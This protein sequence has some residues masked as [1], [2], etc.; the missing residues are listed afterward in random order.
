MRFITLLLVLGSALALTIASGCKKES[1]STSQTSLPSTDSNVQTAE[2]TEPTL[3][4]YSDEQRLF[5]LSYPSDWRISPNI[6]AVEARV[7]ETMQKLMSGQ[8]V[9]SFSLL[10]AV[11]RP[12]DVGLNPNVTIG[13]QT[14]PVVLTVD[15]AAEGSVQGIKQVDPGYKE[16]SRTRTSIDGKDA[17]IIELEAALPGTQ[18]YHFLQLYIV[19]EKTVWVVQCITTIDEFPTYRNMLDKVLRSFRISLH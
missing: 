18:R 7:K 9:E 11:G 3:T 13:V 10:F 8:D 12:A 6:G 16:I 4:A 19:N 1:A 17:V 2:P 14:L 15:Q 5:S